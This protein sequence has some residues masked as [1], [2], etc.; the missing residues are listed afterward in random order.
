MLVKYTKIESDRSLSANIT[1]FF[2][3]LASASNSVN[4]KPLQ[5]LNIYRAFL[6]F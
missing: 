3:L 2:L 5:I 4:V 1:L 6:I